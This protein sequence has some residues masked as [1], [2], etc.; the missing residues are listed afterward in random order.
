MSDNKPANPGRQKRT[1]HVSGHSGGHRNWVYKCVKP[2]EWGCGPTKSMWTY[3]KRL[4]GI[5][6]GSLVCKWNLAC[7]AR[8]DPS[9]NFLT[10]PRPHKSGTNQLPQRVYIRVQEGKTRGKNASTPSCRNY[11][12][13]CRWFY[14]LSHS[15]Y[16]NEF[17]KKKKKTNK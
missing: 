8:R 16:T 2:F 15:Q 1:D 5:R 9:L 12:H 7:N 10:Q 11:G 17:L 14:E 3:L 6:K 4:A 13:V